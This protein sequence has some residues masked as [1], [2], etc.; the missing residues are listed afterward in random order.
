MTPPEVTPARHGPS[1]AGKVVLVTGASSGIGR[2]ASLAFARAG[3]RVALAAR[4]QELG[5]AVAAEIHELG[6]EAL[7]VRTDVTQAEQVRNL[8]GVTVARWGRL[9]AAFNNAATS[10]GAFAKTADF[11]EEAY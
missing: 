4:R 8:I 6:G 3:A 5:E 11:T 10:E 9:D 7:F 1:M 2:A